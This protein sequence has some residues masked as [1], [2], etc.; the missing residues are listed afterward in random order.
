MSYPENMDR[1]S[2]RRNNEKKIFYLN[3]E[4]PFEIWQRKKGRFHEGEW[5]KNT[6]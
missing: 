4:H 6:K 5:L 1:I 2:P 3:L